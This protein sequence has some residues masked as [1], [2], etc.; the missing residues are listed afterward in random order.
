MV[1]PHKV[2]ASVTSYA[3]ER[4][5]SRE[6]ALSEVEGSSS[7]TARRGRPALHRQV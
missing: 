5:A 2:V 3:V 4:R 1:Y 7:M 6:P